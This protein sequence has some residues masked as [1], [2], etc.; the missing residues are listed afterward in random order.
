ME[1]IYRRLYKTLHIIAI[2]IQ[3]CWLAQKALT[4]NAFSTNM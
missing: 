2:R 3:I 4:K 1:K